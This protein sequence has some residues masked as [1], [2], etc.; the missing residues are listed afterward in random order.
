MTQN[1]Q[2]DFVR[3][4]FEANALLR[5]EMGHRNRVVSEIVIFLMLWMR[6]PV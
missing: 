3:K 2:Y 6:E 1:V 5:Q 4:R